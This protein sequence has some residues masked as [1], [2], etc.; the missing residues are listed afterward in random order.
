MIDVAIVGA[1]PAGLAAGVYAARA[2]LNTVLFEA[3]MVG[4]TAYF[5]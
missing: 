2:G 3:L 4:R 1:G 5:N